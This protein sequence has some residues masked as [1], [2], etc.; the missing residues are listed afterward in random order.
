MFSVRL[1]GSASEG[2]RGAGMRN[3]TVPEKVLGLFILSVPPKT[4]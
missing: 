2:A 4:E 1:A 3:Q